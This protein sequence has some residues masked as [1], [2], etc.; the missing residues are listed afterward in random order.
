[1]NTRVEVHL[2]V[3]E[4][5]Q[6]KTYA[7]RVQNW[8]EVQERRFSRFISTSELC[9]LNASSGWVNV[10][11]AMSEVL[12]LARQFTRLSEG[13][14]KPAILPELEWL[15]YDRTFEELETHQSRKRN[16]ES[17]VEA[18][19]S[20]RW[21]FDPV[22]RMFRRD[23]GTTLDLGGIV[24][25]WCVQEISKWLRAQSDI[26]AFCI[27][28]GGD[29]T[30]WNRHA[31]GKRWTI[32]IEDPF[33]PQR[34]IVGLELHSGAA[35]TSS[36]TKR[37]WVGPN[38]VEVHHL[39]DPRTGSSA[40]GNIVQCTVLGSHLPECE[41]ISKSMCILGEIEG[42]AWLTRQNLT[43]T[44]I[45][46]DEE[47]RIHYRGPKDQLE[48]ITAKLKLDFVHDIQI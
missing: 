36:R 41:V 14:F 10:S 23:P 22:T 39:I 40:E 12:S 21:L 33:E 31:S 15:G 3:S 19:P 11:P 42:L 4:L 6:F 45:W 43:H 35:A 2:S 13:A 29:L 9:N 1:M 17:S 32:Q 25:S 20:R 37:K 27:N 5:S 16:G 28:A 47:F 30:V 48:P 34:D 44:L 8:F 7:L 26:E 18:I 38:G 46:V 24:K